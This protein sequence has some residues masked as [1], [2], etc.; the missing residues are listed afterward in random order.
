MLG[1]A[2]VAWPAGLALAQQ[3]LPAPVR[4]PGLSVEGQGASAESATGPVDGYVARDT[5]TGAKTAT[6]VSEIPQTV[7]VIGREEL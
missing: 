4:L 7:N 2:A 5:E 1:T 3:A 6:P